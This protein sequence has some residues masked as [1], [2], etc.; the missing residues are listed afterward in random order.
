M[1]GGDEGFRALIK[2]AHLLGIKVIVDCT[3]RVSSSHMS[4]RYDGLRLKAVDEHGRIVYHYGANGKSISYDDTTPLN[5]RKKEAWDILLRE[6][7]EVVEKF[8][9]DGFYMENGFD[10]PPVYRINEEEMFRNELESKTSV[11]SNEQIFLGEVIIPNK[12]DGFWA[13]PLHANYPNPFI[14]SFCRN[15]WQKYPHLLLISEAL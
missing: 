4:K 14:M 6:A 10:W 15:L 11:Y 8:G 5:Y 7:F 12:I 9:V 2:Q 3:A 1:L 13:S